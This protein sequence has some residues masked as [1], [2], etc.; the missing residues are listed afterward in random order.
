LAASKRSSVT[1][2]PNMNHAD[3]IAAPEALQMVVSAI[4]APE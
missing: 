3:M 4:S 1:L 2:V